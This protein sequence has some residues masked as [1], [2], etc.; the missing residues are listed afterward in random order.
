MVVLK[1][2]QETFPNGTIALTDL[3]VR[4][5]FRGVDVYC[6]IARHGPKALQQA[7]LCPRLGSLSPTPGSAAASMLLFALVQSQ[8]RNAL[9]SLPLQPRPIERLNRKQ[10]RIATTLPWVAVTTG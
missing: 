9:V 3:G 2:D 6:D 8:P 10:R 5:A 7:N 1:L 4:A